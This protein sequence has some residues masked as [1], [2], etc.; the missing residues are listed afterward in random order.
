MQERSDPPQAVIEEIASILATGYLRLRSARQLR[1]S[2][3][4][5]S[6]EALDSAHVTSPHRSGS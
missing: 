4:Q 1:D 5:Y 2:E 3:D 6:V